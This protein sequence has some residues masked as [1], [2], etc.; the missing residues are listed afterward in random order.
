MTE[1]EWR[2][3]LAGEMRSGK[4]A[5]EWTGYALWAVWPTLVLLAIVMIG[6]LVTGKGY[7][8]APVLT[9]VMGMFLASVA[10]LLFAGFRAQVRRSEEK[11]AGCTTATNE[12]P[13]LPQIDPRT[14][15]IVRL[16][17]EPLLSREQ[18]Q[19]RIRLID[20]AIAEEEAATRIVGSTSG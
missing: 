6:M 11:R 5:W 8:E 18:Y 20:E 9:V 13:H 7:A 12:F 2:P 15:R 14:K 3:D 16:A 1:E 10:Y 19:D 17:G 4:S